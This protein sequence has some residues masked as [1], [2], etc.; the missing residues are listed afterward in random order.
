VEIIAQYLNWSKYIN[1]KGKNSYG[2]SSEMISERAEEIKELLEKKNSRYT[3]QYNSNTDR[4][5][6]S[7]LQQTKTK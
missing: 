5:E 1:E 2:I 7:L 6:L 3:L 4:Y